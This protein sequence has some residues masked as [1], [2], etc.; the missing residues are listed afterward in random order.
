M[1]LFMRGAALLSGSFL[2]WKFI[3]MIS[4][5]LGLLFY[6]VLFARISFKHTL[7]ILNIRVD[8][9]CAFSFFSIRSYLL[10]LIMIG[11]GIFL[12]YTDSVDPVLIGLLYLIMGI[13]LILSSLRFWYYGIRYSKLQS[14]FD[15]AEAKHGHKL[16]RWQRWVR[17]FLYIGV[18]AVIMVVALSNWMVTHY[19]SPHIYSDPTL[20]PD[21]KVGVV[22][23]TSSMLASG[24]INLFFKYRVEAAADLYNRGKIQFIIISGDNGTHSYNE[25]REMK[26]ALIA[27]G[28]PDSVIYPD[29]AGFRTFDSMIR[30]W[31][32]FGQKKFTV[33]SQ[34][35]QN[36][37]AVFIARQ[38]GIEAVAYNAKDVSKYSGFKTLLREVLA[39]VNTFL[40]IYVLNM[41]PRFLGDPILIGE[42][43]SVV[44]DSK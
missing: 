27:L 15:R 21:N 43:V 14:D 6:L 41:Q 42:P 16:P 19:S 3:F 29:Y 9:P 22:P 13:P 17:T 39:R 10:M 20:L 35:F 7:R 40:D 26:E 18:I 33:V 36:E 31:K 11:A 44:Q 25:P 2:P 8:R 12:R 5:P 1:I 28:V 32:V 24:T 37:R 38:Y 23:G 4:I 34:R 30:A